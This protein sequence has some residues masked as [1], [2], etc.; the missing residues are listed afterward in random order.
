M[1]LPI[2]INTFKSFNI[3]VFAVFDQHLE[4]PRVDLNH[5]VDQLVSEE[6]EE[7]MKNATARLSN[8]TA[9]PWPCSVECLEKQ[10]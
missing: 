10:E 6:V 3:H 8:S 7:E 1:D 2:G 9:L 4:P 5:P